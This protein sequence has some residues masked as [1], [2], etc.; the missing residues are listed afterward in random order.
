MPGWTREGPEMEPRR[1]REQFVGPWLY[2]AHL[3]GVLVATDPRIAK[4]A[5]VL[6]GD[7]RHQ[8]DHFGLGVASSVPVSQ[9]E[10]CD[11]LNRNADSDGEAGEF[12]GREDP[13]EFVFQ[14]RIGQVCRRLQ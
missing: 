6:R 4:E 12:L 2:G 1:S 8:I 13:G 7:H 11:P 3:S 10:G 5:R 14:V 9:Q